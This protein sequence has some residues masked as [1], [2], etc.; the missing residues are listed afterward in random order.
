MPRKS[1]QV[2]NADL[3]IV[4]YG[5]GCPDLSGPAGALRRGPPWRELAGAFK[6][7]GNKAAVQFIELGPCMPGLGQGH[8][9]KKDIPMLNY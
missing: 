8:E 7:N 5:S 4:G 1:G 2:R 3:T 6:R 9:R